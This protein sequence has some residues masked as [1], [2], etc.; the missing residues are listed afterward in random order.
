MGIVR[1][2]KKDFIK[3]DLDITKIRLGFEVKFSNGFA[4][5]TV[6]SV[7]RDSSQCF[8]M[9]IVEISDVTAPVECTGK[10][11]LLL[12]EKIKDPSEIKVVFKMTESGKRYFM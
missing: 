6:S 12:T 4:T 5:Q 2:R 3:D 1:L 8:K 7:I 11:I 9:E 10:K